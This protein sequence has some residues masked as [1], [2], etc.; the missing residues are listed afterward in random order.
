MEDL[1]AS[2]LWLVKGLLRASKSFENQRS[3]A[4]LHYIGFDFKQISDKGVQWPYIVN[5][6]EILIK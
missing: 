3:D 2:D 4:D 1:I 5:W 6:I